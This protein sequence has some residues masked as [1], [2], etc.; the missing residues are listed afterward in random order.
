[1]E[2]IHVDAF[3]LVG[4]G[5]KVKTTHKNQQSDQ[6][7]GNLWQKFHNENIIDLIPHR[8]GDDLYA[9]YHAYEKSDTDNFLYFIGCRVHKKMDIPA[10]LNILE[11][12][13]QK[14]LKHTASG[15]MTGCITDAWQR[16]GQSDIQR[17]YEFD[18]ELYDERS[19]DWKMAEVDLF[20][21]IV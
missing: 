11:V 12:P 20:I 1:M 10:P 9:V 7:C 21:S 15:A 14:Y 3:I 13:S 4:L 5:L 6:D 16:I 19:V 17:K 8:Q 18:F 2:I